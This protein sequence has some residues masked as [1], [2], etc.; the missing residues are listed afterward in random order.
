MMTKIIHR[1]RYK[2]VIHYEARL[3]LKL[4]IPSRKKYRLFIISNQGTQSH[5]LRQIC[6][7]LQQVMPRKI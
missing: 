5:L 2:P 6:Q 7:I 1:M 3:H 4:D